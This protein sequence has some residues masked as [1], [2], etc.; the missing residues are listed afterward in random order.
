MEVDEGELRAALTGGDVALSTFTDEELAAVTPTLA[1]DQRVVPLR[2][3][4]GLTDQARDAAI[5]AGGRSLL[6]RGALSV[7]APEARRDDGRLAD[8]E[9]HG[10]LGVV[11]SVLGS[12][13]LL[14]VAE[15]LLSDGAADVRVWYG[16]EAVA[17]LDEQPEAG[18][19]RF[20][21]R[22]PQR[23]AHALADHLDPLGAARA[24]ADALI[25]QGGDHPPDWGA[26]TA[27]LERRP[28]ARVVARRHR[29]DADGEPLEL[30]VAVDA[31]G[32]WVLTGFVGADGEPLVKAQRASRRTL[33][34][35]AL[36][37]VDASVPD[38]RT[39]R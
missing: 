39:V 30:T 3:L 14:V 31:D 28:L 17:V 11:L 27:A 5:A 7:P 36:Y 26:V 35:L 24:D 15:R 4:H 34:E 21:M 2:S 8:F 32:L 33:E 38:H 19:H 29:V 6:A 9:L 23:A 16:V 18:L 10:D 22:S 12:F 20:V 25:A 1:D 13:S 37:L